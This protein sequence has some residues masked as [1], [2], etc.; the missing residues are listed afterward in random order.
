MHLEHLITNLQ[1]FKIYKFD[2]QIYK[3]DSQ[4]KGGS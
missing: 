3:S 4:Y 2:S 1:I